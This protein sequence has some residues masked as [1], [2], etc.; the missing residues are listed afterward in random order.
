MRRR[1]GVLALDAVAARHVAAERGEHGDAQLV[2]ALPHALEV[3][4]QGSVVLF[5]RRDEEP[6]VAKRG[7][8][9]VERNRIV[10]IE[11]SG[12]SPDEARLEHVLRH[13]G[14]GVRQG[15]EQEDVLAGLRTNAGREPRGDQ[16]R[17]LR[18]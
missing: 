7:P 3:L 8:R 1:R 18:F 13:D 10:G 12:A 17:R 4:V 5:R 9:L 14:D 2:P 6:Q 11:V 16:I 15:V